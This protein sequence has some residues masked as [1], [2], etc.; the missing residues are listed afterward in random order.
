MRPAESATKSVV[1]ATRTA[2]LATRQ[3][4]PTAPATMTLTPASAPTTSSKR[5]STKESGVIPATPLSLYSTLSQKILKTNNR[6]LT[7]G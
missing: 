6:Y 1:S 3:P 2:A 4:T 7:P 5:V